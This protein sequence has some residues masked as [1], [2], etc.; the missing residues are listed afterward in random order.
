[1][2]NNCNILLIKSMFLLSLQFYE[3]QNNLNILN[4]GETESGGRLLVR[5]PGGGKLSRVI[6]SR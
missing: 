1:M 6:F 4:R 2:S 5:H 3:I